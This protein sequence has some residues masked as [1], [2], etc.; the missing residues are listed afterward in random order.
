VTAAAITGG[1]ILPLTLVSALMASK[2][3]Q[4]TYGTGFAVTSLSPLEKAGRVGKP[5]SE[6]NRS[7]SVTAIDG[8]VRR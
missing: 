4:S 2:K 8:K 1:N 7:H 3:R 5:A 6:S